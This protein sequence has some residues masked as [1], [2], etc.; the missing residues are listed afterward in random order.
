MCHLDH[1]RWTQRGTHTLVLR[2]PQHIPVLFLGASLDDR[3]RKRASAQA[4]QREKLPHQGFPASLWQTRRLWSLKGAPR[5][6][7]RP[8]LCPQT[9]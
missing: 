7:F 9:I 5:C 8:P 4:A 1:S 6:P 2:W 3:R